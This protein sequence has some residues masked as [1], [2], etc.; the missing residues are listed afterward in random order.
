M[1]VDKFG[2]HSKSGGGG[3]GKSI[4][5]PRGIGFKLTAD[6]DYDISSKRLVNL[7]KAVDDGDA[8]NK[9]TLDETLH[10]KEEI[11]KK[12]VDGVV[13]TSTKSYWGFGNR[14]LVSVAGPKDKQDAV[15]VEFLKRMAICFNGKIFDASNVR[16]SNVGAPKEDTDAVNLQHLNRELATLIADI[17]ALTAR[18]DHHKSHLELHF[19]KIQKNERRAERQLQ[20][21]G[22][23]LFRFLQRYED[24]LP[25]PVAHMVG[26][27]TRYN[28]VDWDAIRRVPDDDRAY[29]PLF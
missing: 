9:K 28:Y 19:S 25:Q 24:V 15:N 10:S 23:L 5:G 8:V 18:V 11:I 12:Y 26:D 4:A 21:Y 22:S 1:S 14:R 7:G 13:P 16:V 17:K 20:R 2:R 27:V 29:D 3:S 6:S